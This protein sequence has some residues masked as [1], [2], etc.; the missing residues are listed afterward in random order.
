MWVR[1]DEG[2]GARGAKPPARHWSDSRGA[3]LRH[4][5]LQRWPRFIDWIFPMS[6][7]GI[8]TIHKDT[9]VNLLVWEI[10]TIHLKSKEIV[11]GIPL[12]VR[13]L[14]RYSRNAGV[15]WLCPRSLLI[16]WKRSACRV[17]SLCSVLPSAIC[18]DAKEFYFCSQFFVW[19]SAK[20]F[21]SSNY[22]MYD[23]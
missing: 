11:P 9:T 12:C 14:N 22:F 2:W 4:R 18:A 10:P 21:F 7:R 23:S 6:T 16:L 1:E 8:C 17:Y 19:F 13:V 3:T 20:A 5:Q 15:T